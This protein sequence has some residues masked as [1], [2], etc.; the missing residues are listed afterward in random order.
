LAGADIVRAAEF[1]GMSAAAFERQYVQRTR[2]PTPLAGAVRIAMQ[3]LARWR[4][5]D[6]P[7]QTHAVPDFPVLAGTGGKPAGVPEDGALLPGCWA[8][9]ADLDRHGSIAGARVAGAV[10]GNA[11]NSG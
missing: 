9:S 6:P 10:P 4:L 7:G 8:G 2:E 11:R 1:L 3:L 5:L